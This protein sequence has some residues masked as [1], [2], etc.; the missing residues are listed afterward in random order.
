MTQAKHG[1]KEK[2]FMTH[3]GKEFSSTHYIDISDEK[4]QEIKKDFFIK[5]TLKQV[6]QEMYNLHYNRSIKIGKITDYF[7]SDMIYD[8]K[9]YT[10]KWTINEFFESNDLIRFA[11]A[12]VINCSDFYKEKDG[13]IKNIKTV[14]RLSPSRTAAKVS[15]Y[16]LSSV[17][18]I[19]KKYSKEASNGYYDYSCGWGVRLMGA[20]TSGIQYYGTDPNFKLTEQLDKLGNM[21]NEVNHIKIPFKIYTQGS[22]KLIPE[23]KNNIGIAFSSPP[24]F[25]LEDYG[26]G[27]QSI[28]NRSYEQWLEEY[29]RVT[30]QNIQLYLKDDGVFLLNIKSFEQFDLLNDMKDIA[31]Q[32]GFTYIESLNLK[33]IQRIMLKNSGVSS[34]EQILVFRKIGYKEESKELEIW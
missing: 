32:E 21:Y 1:N 27:E 22:E 14:L 7:V 17:K 12:K 10:S 4:C 5:P 28:N 2:T 3:L 25:D 9:L 15:N 24:Y 29:W 8:T 18:E 19:L 6:Q 23:L 33:N 16:P 30:V 31:L 26:T 34:D 13:I 11:Y 20:L